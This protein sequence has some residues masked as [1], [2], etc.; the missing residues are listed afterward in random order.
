M[1]IVIFDSN[2]FLS[3]VFGE[4]CYFE[5]IKK[6]VIVFI[7]RNEVYYMFSYYLDFE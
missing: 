1:L 2:Y 7:V 5:K 4:I 3:F 6:N